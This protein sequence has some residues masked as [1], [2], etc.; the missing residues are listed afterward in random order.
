MAFTRDEGEFTIS[1]LTAGNLHRL[2]VIAEGWGAGEA[3]RVEAQPVDR[4]KP[5][6]AVTIKLAALHSLRV[7]VFRA[8]GKLV[9]GDARDRDP[10]RG[11]RR[12]P[13]GL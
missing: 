7:R 9:E 1:G 13:V 3:D 6:D 4:L 8:E 5:A 10:A 12:I 11:A 2:T